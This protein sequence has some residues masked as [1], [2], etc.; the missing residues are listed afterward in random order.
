LLSRPTIVDYIEYGEYILKMLRHLHWTLPTLFISWEGLSLV[1]LGIWGS[2]LPAAATNILSI[3]Y[4][5]FLP[6]VS[7]FKKIGLSSGE[8][9]T[10]PS[11]GGF[12][13]ASIVY[14][15]ILF[16]IGRAIQMIAGHRVR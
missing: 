16:G 14:C 11:L 13:L 4:I 2:D 3:V 6:F 10:L 12:F 8:Y 1:L 15:L 7:L 5:P 9:W